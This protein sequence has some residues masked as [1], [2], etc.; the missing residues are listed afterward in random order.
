VL[1]FNG[2]GMVVMKDNQPPS[3]TSARVLVFEGG[4]MVM[5][6]DNYHQKRACALV[7]EGGGMWGTSYNLNIQ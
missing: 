1:V 6:K 3:K 2:G 5:M 4:G 7:F